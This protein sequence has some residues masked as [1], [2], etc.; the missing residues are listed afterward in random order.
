ML[1]IVVPGF[2][3]F[4][5]VPR[6]CWVAQKPMRFRVV[7]PAFVPVLVTFANFRDGVYRIHP[8]MGMSGL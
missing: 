5:V 2:G 4:A 1:W 8:Q 6:G 7:V 3:R